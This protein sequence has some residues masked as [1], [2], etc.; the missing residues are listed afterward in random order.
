MQHGNHV[1]DALNHCIALVK[2]ILNAHAFDEPTR[3]CGAGA[4]RS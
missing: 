1:A 2:Q 4:R 3:K